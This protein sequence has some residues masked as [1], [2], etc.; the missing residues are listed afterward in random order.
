MNKR[1]RVRRHAANI[2]SSLELHRRDTSG[3]LI[4]MVKLNYHIWIDSLEGHD[5]STL[6]TVV[7][8]HQPA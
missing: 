5:T 3:Y 4:R 2:Q 1:T 7:K 6:V 8:G